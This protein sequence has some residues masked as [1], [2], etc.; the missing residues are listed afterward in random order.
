MFTESED[1]DDAMRKSERQRHPA[2]HLQEYLD[3]RSMTQADLARASGLTTSHICQLLQRTRPFT[4][5]V[6]L[7]L[8][9]ALGV[10]ANIWV[11]L[12]VHWDLHEARSNQY[13]HME[14]P[15][16]QG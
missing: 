3:V 9:E 5:R 7:A 13:D 8:E 11:S 6:A 1:G 4:P 15:D 2:D 12:Q 16:E 10:S 14:L